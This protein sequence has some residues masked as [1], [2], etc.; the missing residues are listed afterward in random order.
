MH[1]RQKP[2]SGGAASGVG[3]ENQC[4]GS[5]QKPGLEVKA[6]QPHITAASAAR[7]SLLHHGL[8]ALASAMGLR[9]GQAAW[10]E[11]LSPAAAAPDVLMVPLAECGGSYCLQYMIDSSGPFRAVVDT[12]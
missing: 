11:G 5:A 2:E 4:M 7:R 8:W 1:S 6:T 10:S 3:N 9:A 12:G